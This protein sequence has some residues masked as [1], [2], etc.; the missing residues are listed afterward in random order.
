[1][2]RRLR[3]LE[4]HGEGTPVSLEFDQYNEN[5]KKHDHYTFRCGEPPRG[6]LWKALQGMGRHALDFCGLEEDADVAVTGVSISY[7]KREIQGLIITASV[8][9]EG[10]K[11]PFNF[12]TPRYSEGT[13]EEEE[14]PGVFSGECGEDLNE[15]AKLAFAYLKGDRAQLEL[16]LVQR[17]APAGEGVGEAVVEEN[18]QQPELVEA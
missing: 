4:Y 5:T 8:D 11:S 3:K 2:G 6:A 7:D 10:S 18:T 15:L 13:G 14:E 1:M 9:L 16:E 12:N 17:D